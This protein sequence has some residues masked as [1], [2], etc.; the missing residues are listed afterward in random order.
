MPEQQ[1]N[2]GAKSKPEV[3][4]LGGDLAKASGA[5]EGEQLGID[6]DGN[7]VAIYREVVRHSAKRQAILELRSEA[8]LSAQADK[9]DRLE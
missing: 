6:E 9:L 4:R 2:H 3:K 5:H 1:Q 8:L 7:V